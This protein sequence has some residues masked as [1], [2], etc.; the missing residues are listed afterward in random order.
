[1]EAGAKDQGV[2][3]CVVAQTSSEP[4]QPNKVFRET[5][6]INFYLV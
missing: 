3:W 5:P 1:M 6:A 2:R 4:L